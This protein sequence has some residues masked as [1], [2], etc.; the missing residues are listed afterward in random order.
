VRTS[1]PRYESAAVTAAPALRRVLTRWDLTAVG[2]NQVVGS[3]IFLL[4]APIALHVG[5]WSP[6]AIL[7]GG[8]ATLIVS[9]CFAEAGSRFESTGGPYLYT[10]AAFGRFASFEVGWMAWFTRATAQAAVTA[11]LTLAIGFYVPGATSGWGRA[12]VV[13]VLTLAIGAVTLRGIRQSAWLVDVLTI[14]KLVP[15]AVFILVGLTHVDLSRLTPLPD[16]TGRDALA[17]ALLMMFLYGGF[18]VIGVP[19]GETTRPRHDVPFALVTTVVTVTAIYTLAQTVATTTLPGLGTS[20]TPLADSALVTMG[21][22]GALLISAGSIFAM[23]GN[24]AGQVL[25]GSRFLY[26][27]AEN[28]DL[29]RWFAYVHPRFRTPSHGVIFTTLVS[30]A[31]AL[32]GS[33]AALASAS[34][35]ARLLVYGG[36]CGATLALRQPRF[37]GR[38]PPAAFTIPL[39]PV[40]PALGVLLS[41]AIMGGATR[42]QVIGG[43][44]FLALG[45]VLYMLARRGT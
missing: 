14:A 7:A 29:P 44:G 39:G 30:L 34:A 27:L 15:L 13:T 6:V 1:S 33:F 11:G 5:G 35:V 37:D 18:E 20:T 28:G 24:I 2:I 41:L 21:R 3:A 19:A 17:A 32:T 36:T 42:A 23:T 16:V 38:V 4:P 12:G 22:P 43:V 8:A 25:A 45:A 26:A 10:R 31:L 9:L 40:V